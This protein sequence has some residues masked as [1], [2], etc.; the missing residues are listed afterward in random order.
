ML[1]RGYKTR[2]ELV[3]VTGVLWS[4]WDREERWG[5]EGVSVFEVLVPETGPT[6]GDVLVG[7]PT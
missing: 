6:N 1:G 7:V 2:G 3:R 4:K 5:R